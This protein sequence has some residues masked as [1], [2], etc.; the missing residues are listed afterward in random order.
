MKNTTNSNQKFLRLAFLF[1]LMLGGCTNDDL[2]SY[3][4]EG[5]VIGPDVKMCVCCGGWEITIDNKT[6]HFEMPS[7]SGINADKDKFPLKVKLNWNID[8]TACKWIIVRDI[9]KI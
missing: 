6:Y 7:N 1:S 8:N 2:V 4:S 9:K 3:K 5:T